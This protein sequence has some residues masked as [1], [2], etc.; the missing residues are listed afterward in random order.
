MGQLGGTRDG[1]PCR[2]D[3]ILEQRVGPGPN[4]GYV[5]VEENLGKMRGLRK[6]AAPRPLAGSVVSQ[7]VVW[8][9]ASVARQ[10]LR[11]PCPRNQDVAATPQS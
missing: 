3:H 1:E 2:H 10:V 4:D 5:S 7:G 9:V 6:A 11:T 8:T